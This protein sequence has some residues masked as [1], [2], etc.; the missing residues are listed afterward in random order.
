[1]LVT[2]HRLDAGHNLSELYGMLRRFVQLAKNLVSIQHIEYVALMAVPGSRSS[3]GELD[4]S[5]V[6][7]FRIVMAFHGTFCSK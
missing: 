2:Q 7:K 6:L 1:M 5:F 4:G 3:H